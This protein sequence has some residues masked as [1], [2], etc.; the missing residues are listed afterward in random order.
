MRESIEYSIAAAFGA[1]CLCLGD[2]VKETSTMV[3][4]LEPIL[5]KLL[6]GW[7]PGGF[8]TI[9][10]IMALAAGVCWVFAPKS[11][12]DA[13]S[14]GFAIFAVLT[15]GTPYNQLVLDQQNAKATGQVSSPT[16]NDEVD[17]S[18][19]PEQGLINFLI[20]PAQAYAQVGQSH[21]PSAINP[22]NQWKGANATIYSNTW[23]SSCKPNSDT[24]VK[25]WQSFFNNTIILYY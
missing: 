15:T 20:S 2:L 14:R 21:S 23:V 10:F 12:I 9:L 1:F 6:W 11:R 24:F 22:D 18:E 13:F 25:K 5:R 17:T 8:L 19:K 16:I 4:M 3:L 7:W